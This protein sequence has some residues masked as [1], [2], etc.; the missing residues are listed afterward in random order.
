MLLILILI[1][2]AR[3]QNVQISHIVG[4]P[5]CYLWNVIC[6]MMMVIIY[7]LILMGSKSKDG[8]NKQLGQGVPP[9]SMGLNNSF[10]YKILVCHF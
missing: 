5:W 8:G 9:Y 3:G 2:Q 1:G 10:T 4:Q 6:E 7:K